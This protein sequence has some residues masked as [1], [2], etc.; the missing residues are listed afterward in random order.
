MP[1]ITKT[2]ILTK[3]AYYNGRMY[4]PDTEQDWPED[5]ADE[6]IEKDAA[7]PVMDVQPA[8]GSLR[9]AL[10]DQKKKELIIFA[11]QDCIDNGD[12]N[13][14][15]SPKVEVMEDILGFN[16]TSAQRDEAWETL[17]REQ[18]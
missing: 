17:K 13:K 16:I 14:D 8:S 1:E 18:G 11:A 6:L 7:E 15:K 3:S 12:I 10:E 4:P 5:I 9:S 2:I